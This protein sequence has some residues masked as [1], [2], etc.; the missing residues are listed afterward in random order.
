M[1]AWD[2]LAQ[3]CWHGDLLILLRRKYFSQC[4]FVDCPTYLLFIIPSNYHYHHNQTLTLSLRVIPDA[5][6]RK[7]ILALLSHPF[8][9]HNQGRILESRSTWK[10]NLNLRHLSLMLHLTLFTYSVGHNFKSQHREEIETFSMDF[11]QLMM[12]D[13]IH[14]K[15]KTSTVHHSQFALH[16]AVLFILESSGS[17]Q[18]FC[19]DYQFSF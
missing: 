14:P 8:S 16:L 3:V 11:V 15:G 13:P 4:F 19:I 6:Q 10:L 1:N 9:H 12:E 7:L 5:L 18:I 2:H 17:C